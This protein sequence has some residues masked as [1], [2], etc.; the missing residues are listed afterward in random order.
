[1]KTIRLLLALLTAAL[2]ATACSKAPD[3]AKQTSAPHVHNAPHG[4][5]LIELGDH[6]YQLELVRDNATG[7]LTA[8]VLDGH[9]ENFVRITSPTFQLIAMPGG[10]FTPLTLHAVANPSTGETV[11]DTAQFVVQVD[12][13]KTA[14]DFS[15]IFT[16]EI[17]G[18]K[19]TQV[20][21]HLPEH[22]PLP[23]RRRQLG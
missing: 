3:P 2:L 10:K 18:T 7:T 20:P 21:Y 17:R 8:Y 5:I 19:F 23:P 13:L 22:P 15:G 6:A 16:I 4:G 11:G 12:W 14:P 1:M 9:A